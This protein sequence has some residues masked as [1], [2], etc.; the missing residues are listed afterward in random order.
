VHGIAWDEAERAFWNPRLHPRDPGGK[1]AA[2]AGE[3]DALANEVQHEHFVNAFLGGTAKVDDAGALAPAAAHLHDAADALRKGDTHGAEANLAEAE[4]HAAAMP[5]KRMKGHHHKIK[6]HHHHLRKY[7]GGSSFGESLAGELAGALAARAFNPRQP[8]DPHTGKWVAVAGHLDKLASEIGHHPSAVAARRAASALRHGDR[9]GAI[10]HLASAHRQA[11]TMRGGERHVVAI[12]RHLA[13]LME[14]QPMTPEELASLAGHIPP[15]MEAPATHVGLAML[16]L[17]GGPGDLAAMLAAEPKPPRVW[18]GGVARFSRWGLAERLADLADADPK[19]EAVRAAAGGHHIPGTPYHYRHGWIPVA[20]YF[21]QPGDLQPGDVVEFRGH[22]HMVLQAPGQAGRVNLPPDKGSGVYLR[23][24]AGSSIFPESGVK[25]YATARVHQHKMIGPGIVGVQTVTGKGEVLGGAAKVDL[26]SSAFAQH[27]RA[28]DDLAASLPGVIG[29]GETRPLNGAQIYDRFP[30]RPGES[31]GAYRR[32]IY[33][34]SMP[35]NLVSTTTARP[36]HGNHAIGG[37]TIP[38]LATPGKPPHITNV[39]PDRQLQPLM[40]PADPAMNGPQ[41][42]DMDEAVTQIAF[43]LIRNAQGPLGDYP[44]AAEMLRFWPPHVSESPVDYRNRLAA[45]TPK[46][47]KD[48]AEV[49]RGR[50]RVGA[51]GLGAQFAAGPEPDHRPEW[52]KAAGLVWNSQFGW[53]VESDNAR[54]LAGDSLPPGSAPHVQVPSSALAPEGESRVQVLGKGVTPEEVSLIHSIESGVRSTDEEGVGGAQSEAE[55]L[56]LNDGERVMHKSY[57]SWDQGGDFSPADLADAEYLSG[58]VADVIGGTGAPAVVRGDTPDDI[59]MQFKDMEIAANWLSDR[60]IDYGDPFSSSPDT[61][62]NPQSYRIGLL[63]YLTQNSD[64]HYH[65]YGFDAD[66]NPVPIDHSSTFG[67]QGGG[68]DSPFLQAADTALEHH[69]SDAIS[70]AELD[71]IG[72]RLEHVKGQFTDA[73]RGD[74]YNGVL[75]R[76]AEFR[77][78]TETGQF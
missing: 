42:K 29:P 59:Y 50:A 65:N 23:P 36:G 75:S 16:G 43:G 41:P 54:L 78:A 46:D 73:G 74:W 12:D 24:I 57:L 48:G 32:R 25:H 64:R 72:K 34:M 13:G 18:T 2:K 11:A 70:V 68:W 20:P 17:E 76:L 14:P 56:T 19:G 31:A 9:E 10:R 39:K 33:G 67:I 51:G 1:W 21:K 45:M 26:F 52:A 77:R 53:V 58:Q 55:F 37:G 61:F 7:N 8:R 22:K 47:F 44:N 30:P 3:L 62:M 66:G 38:S 15:G 63:D 69:R 4:R 27:Q 5:G 35:H 60:G 40:T 6:G 71:E 49:A 28:A